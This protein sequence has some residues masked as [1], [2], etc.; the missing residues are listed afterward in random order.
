MLDITMSRSSEER[1]ED[2]TRALD[3]AIRDLENAEMHDPEIREDFREASE[4]Y[5]E[6]YERPVEGW[7]R[8][9]EYKAAEKFE[10]ETLP[11]TPEGQKLVWD[12]KR[13]VADTFGLRDYVPDS[14]SKYGGRWEFTRPIYEGDDQ[15]IFDPSSPGDWRK[16]S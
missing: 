7:M 9:D 6:W 2:R 12:A 11:N 10:L 15:T 8:T 16:A 1:I 5:R 3:S 4:I 13:L 14:N